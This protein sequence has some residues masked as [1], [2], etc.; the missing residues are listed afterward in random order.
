MIIGIESSCDESALALFDPASGFRG[1]WVHSQI[2]KHQAYGGIVPDLASREH[3]D[4]FPALLK[5]LLKEY[6]PV[7]GDT[8]AVTSG[9]GLAGC[10]ALGMTVARSLSLAYGSEILGVNHLRGHAF[11]PFIEL[12][13]GNPQSFGER[14]KEEL[15]H[16]G[17][18]VSGGNTVLFGIDEAGTLSV[19]ANTV[20]DAAGEALD[21]GAKLLGMP[22]PGGPLIEERARGGNTRAFDFPRSFPA[23]NDFR[24]SFSGLKTSL[25]YL[26][27]KLTD[28]ELEKSL[29]DI[30]AS[31]QQAVVDA[32]IRKT[33]HLMKQG[34][35]RSLGLSGGVA[36]N[37]C[38]RE[39]FLQLGQ[40][41]R[42]PVHIACPAHTGDNAAMIA[43]A[44][45]MDRKGC[46]H[47]PPAFDPSWE[48][49]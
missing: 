18:I 32:L 23:S 37:S 13:A 36:N 22:Y 2:L 11:S 35:F 38:L 42:L 8:I 6:E 44:A 24:F 12:H 49:A 30:C 21:K 45:F 14:F 4:N 46:L 7:Q 29:P 34:G 19:L 9:P 3:L 5:E 26:L 10:L 16:L 48:L 43:F 1:E 41:R 39:A 31:Y 28:A 20:D 27:E 25:R 47:N 17:L 40:S 15:P 33:G